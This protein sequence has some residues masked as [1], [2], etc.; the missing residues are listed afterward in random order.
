MAAAA[1]AGFAYLLIASGALHLLRG[2]AVTGIW[3]LLIGWFLKEAASG[4]VRQVTLEDAL[5]RYRV[6]DVMAHDVT[7]LPAGLSAEEAVQD[8]FARTGYAAYP[9]VRGETV[10][11]LVA[12]RD[13]VRLRAEDRTGTSV[14]A[15]MIPLTEELTASPQ[16]LLGEA[17]H[18]MNRGREGRLVVMDGDRLAGFL[19]PRGVLKALSA[20]GRPAPSAG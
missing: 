9:V 20:S 6:A 10:V 4:A 16:E 11:G 19:T 14:Q 13:V 2:A 18:R 7:A 15:V 17:L 12:L 8:H 3:H 1:G 5:A